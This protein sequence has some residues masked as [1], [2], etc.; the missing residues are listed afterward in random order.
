MESLN[1]ILEENYVLVAFVILIR[2]FCSL[3]H[4]DFF[5]QDGDA[6]CHL[7]ILKSLSIRN[8]DYP[9]GFHRLSLII[10]KSLNEILPGSFNLII[11][12]IFVITF[13][14]FYQINLYSALYLILISIL[15][16]EYN[17]HQFGYSE[18]FCAQ[19]CC[20]LVF[21]GILLKWSFIW[22]TPF[23]IY[24]ITSSKFGRQFA[25]FICLPCLLVTLQFYNL[26][27][28]TIL[29]SIILILSPRIRREIKHQI[30][31]TVNYNKHSTIN[32][33]FKWR[34]FYEFHFLRILLFPELVILYFY[35]FEIFLV[36]ISVFLVISLRKFSRVGESW[37][38]LEWAL[39]VPTIILLS[40]QYAYILFFKLFGF[41][42]YSAILKTK[43]RNTIYDYKTDAR[44]ITKF[45]EGKGTILPIPYRAGDEL[46]SVDPQ[47]DLI[48]WWPIDGNNCWK[49]L[50]SRLVTYDPQLSNESSWVVFN[51]K[52][53]KQMDYDYLESL[54]NREIVISNSS[55]FVVKADSA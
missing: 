17:K 38:Y 8:I 39:F 18:R 3:S 52:L 12:C 32:N 13:N 19:L 24:I 31:F 28:L 16:D 37:R 15:V 26:L 50:P 46:V 41:L 34:I 35:N 11:W 29:Y 36:L 14:F 21:C 44:E 51:K 23:Y 30:D 5:V 4:N 22:V 2:L 20:S 45:L 48:K 10:G 1:Y 54:V 55:Y 7:A 42:L 47:V 6:K 49:K 27:Y 40:E 53:L 43:L 33:A 9:T 25:F